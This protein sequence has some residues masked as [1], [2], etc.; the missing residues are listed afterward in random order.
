M[1][2]ANMSIMW[3][4][5]QSK[6]RVMEIMGKAVF[7]GPHTPK[8][9]LVIYNILSSNQETKGHIIW[10]QFS[11]SLE[12]MTK[13]D[14]IKKVKKDVGEELQMLGYNTRGKTLKEMQEIATI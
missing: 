8:Q 12:N 9:K 10:I 3:R 11:S 14:E 2:V 13:K 5:K 1:N 4:G 6:V 7:L